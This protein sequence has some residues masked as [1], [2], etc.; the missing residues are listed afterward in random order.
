MILV[1]IFV[2]L[3]AI[4]ILELL[5]GL[6]EVDHAD[7]RTIHYFNITKIVPKAPQDTLTGSML[8]RF[9]QVYGTDY[10]TPT[11]DIHAYDPN[12][13]YNNRTTAF[14]YKNFLKAHI[15]KLSKT[16]FF[17]DEENSLEFLSIN[18]AWSQSQPYTNIALN[19]L[20]DEKLFGLKTLNPHHHE[21]QE[22][23]HCFYQFI[24]GAIEAASYDVNF[25]NFVASFHHPNNDTRFIIHYDQLKCYA[26]NTLQASDF[27]KI[28]CQSNKSNLCH[29]SYNP[30]VEPDN[31]F[32]PDQWR[33][34]HEKP[35]DY[36]FIPI[37]EQSNIV[38]IAA[39]DDIIVYTVAD[40]RLQI[41]C[42]FRNSSGH[43]VPQTIDYYSSAKEHRVHQNLGLQF[44]MNSP[45]NEKQLLI[46]DILDKDKTLQLVYFIFRFVSG[47]SLL[48]DPELRSHYHFENLDDIE[49]NKIYG[50]VLLELTRR[51]VTQELTGIDVLNTAGLPK[52]IIKNRADAKETLVV[53]LQK[54]VMVIT[55]TGS[56]KYLHTYPIRDFEE[57]SYRIKSV[58][59][60]EDGVFLAFLTFN[61]NEMRV[62]VYQMETFD[63]DEQL[64]LIN[65]DYSLDPEEGEIKDVKFSTSIDGEPILMILM[66]SGEVVSFSLHLGKSSLGMLRNTLVSGNLDL[67]SILSLFAIVIMFIFV[68]LFNTLGLQITLRQPP[69]PA[70]QR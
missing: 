8:K 61:L 29:N 47:N 58:D 49:P 54:Y 24:E 70:A 32:Y 5:N 19:T 42:F 30:V 16:Y 36:E 64:Y 17:N 25:G 18:S 14:F 2:G 57:Q 27:R 44:M 38:N 15:H 45:K 41:K 35:H 55:D 22:W 28:Y 60:S 33:L 65:F 53:S 9:H 48:T 68:K 4:F 43:W 56:L 40:E 67:F 20:K 39:T 66:E 13:V 62:F 69:P 26:N 23:Q 3:F 52:T 6:R 31:G 34:N 7:A 51:D 37:D 10:T 46:V 11:S 63:D 1:Y 50:S 12:S 59:I 21:Q